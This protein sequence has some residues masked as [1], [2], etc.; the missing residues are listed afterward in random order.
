MATIAEK[1]ENIAENEQHVWDSGYRTGYCAA[2]GEAEEITV[3][4]TFEEQEIVPTEPNLIS[5]V[6]VE[7]GQGLYDQGKQTEYDEFWDVFQSKGNRNRY[8]FGFCYWNEDN[9][10]PKYNIIATYSTYMFSYYASQTDLIDHLEKLGITI[11][12]SDCT[13]IS[14]MFQNAQFTTFPTMD[15]RKATTFSYAWQ[16]AANLKTI[17]KI[18]LNSNGNQS[19]HNTTFLGCKSLENIEFEGVIGSVLNMKDSPL[20]KKSMTNIINVLSAT[21][22][23]KTLTLSLS[24]VNNAFETSEGAADGSTSQEWLDLIATKSNWTI[25]LV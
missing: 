17:Q 14:Y 9:F 11:D 6:T 19:F 3:T 22:S 12:W 23:S 10:K 24:A 5:K 4:P 18:I 1:L 2:K 21:A 7:S 25:S 13:S 20:T 16:N 15:L 8:T